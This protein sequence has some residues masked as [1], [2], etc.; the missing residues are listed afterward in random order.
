M[1]HE[2]PRAPHLLPYEGLLRAIG[3][4]VDSMGG[5]NLLIIDTGDGFSIRFSRGSLGETDHVEFSYRGLAEQETLQLANRQPKPH[6][7]KDAPL[8]RGTGYQDF[9]RAFGAQLESDEQFLV[10]LDEQPAGFIM[11]YIYMDPER[12]L[13]PHKTMATLSQSDVE[14]LREEGFSRR[15]AEGKGPRWKRFLG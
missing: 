6:A 9:L 5:K 11:S 1:Q 15:K 3:D 13:F 4:H 14:R 7:A 10:L 8:V 12:A 2:Q